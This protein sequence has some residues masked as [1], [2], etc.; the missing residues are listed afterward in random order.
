MLQ[1]IEQHNFTGANFDIGGKG[2]SLHL[3]WKGELVCPLCYFCLRSFL[4]CPL[5]LLLFSTRLW[6]VDEFV[7]FFPLHPPVLEP[8]LYLAFCQAQSVR[9]FDT[10][11]PGQVPVK[12]ELFLQLQRLVT[13]VCL[14]TPSARVTKGSYSKERKENVKQ[15]L[16]MFAIM[17]NM[18]ENDF[19]VPS[20]L[21]TREPRT[22]M[23]MLFKLSCCT[24]KCQ[25]PSYSPVLRN[26]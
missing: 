8:N 25:V 7:F 24:T 6:G 1:R 17:T 4:F 2:I 10:A 11:P 5:L 22:F 13:S 21:E 15:V 9:D 23:R 18:R 26:V 16:G 12:M 14:T 19:R 3:F 20:W